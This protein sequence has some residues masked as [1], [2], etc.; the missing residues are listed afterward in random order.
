MEKFI[1]NVDKSAICLAYDKIWRTL[2]LSWTSPLSTLQLKISI[3]GHNLDKFLSKV[4]TKIKELQ[5]HLLQ[6]TPY[7]TYD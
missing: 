6:I 1:C 3:F 4:A 7:P 2:I 5:L